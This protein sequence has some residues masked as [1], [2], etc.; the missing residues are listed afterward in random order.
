MS[1]AQIFDLVLLAVLVLVTARYVTRGFLAGLV[2]FV[3]NLASLVGAMVLSGKIAP[4]LF[5]TFLQG[6]LTNQVENAIAQQ[7]SVDIAGLVEKYAGFLP[8]SVQQ[9]LIETASGILDTSAPDV[10]QKVVSELVEPL[11]T[12]LITIVLFFVCFA[13]CK[14]VI[15]FLVAV[16]TN[17]NRVPVVGGVNRVLGLLMGLLAGCM[18]LFLVLCGVWT[19]IV[20]TGDNLPWLNQAALQGSIGYDI[21]MRF[22]PFMAV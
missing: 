19:L 13:L 3:G 21:F 15:S 14:L 18:D 1:A 12:P 20:I 2:Q 16:L 8:R 6:G 7:G 17:L 5:S 22:N 10:A 4:V 11:V 9:S